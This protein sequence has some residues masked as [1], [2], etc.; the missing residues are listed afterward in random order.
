MAQDSMVMFRAATEVKKALKKAARED[1][2]TMSNLALKIVTE[3][4]RDHG[5]LGRAPTDRPRAR[6]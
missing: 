1:S 3:W 2:R 6:M 4:L 5:H